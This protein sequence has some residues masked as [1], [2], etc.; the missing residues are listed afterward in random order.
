MLDNGR[1]TLANDA[2]EIKR[3]YF[4]QHGEFFEVQD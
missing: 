4:L 2:K 3:A 1:Q